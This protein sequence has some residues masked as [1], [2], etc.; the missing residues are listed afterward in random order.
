M[1]DA[2]FEWAVDRIEELDEICSSDNLSL[3]ALQQKIGIL[4]ESDIGLEHISRVLYIELP[5]SIDKDYPLLHTACRN[6]NVTLEIVK[7][8]INTFPDRKESGQ[9]IFFVQ[10]ICLKHTHCI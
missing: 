1:D 3:S 9:P 5:E 8:L 10:I 2:T 6:K 4:N 7:Y